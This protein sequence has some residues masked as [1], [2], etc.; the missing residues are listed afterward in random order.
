MMGLSVFEWRTGEAS[1]FA[2]DPAMNGRN[3]A[4]AARQ[5]AIKDAKAVV[6]VGSIKT[7]S[8]TPA[9]RNFRLKRRAQ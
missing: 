3:A 6:L 1:I 2:S 4:I 5:R 8:E 9:G 7:E